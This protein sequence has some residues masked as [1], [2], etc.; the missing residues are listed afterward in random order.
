MQDPDASGTDEASNERRHFG[1]LTVTKVAFLFS[2]S[3]PPPLTRI[4]AERRAAGRVLLAQAGVTLGVAAACAVGWGAAAARSAAL[5]GGIGMAAAALMALALFRQAGPVSALRAAWGFYLGQALK[6]ALTIA[7]L[8][9][10][11]RSPGTVP[12]ALLAGYVASFAGYWA[13]PGAPRKG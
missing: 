6:V 7:L 5:G 8:V 3:V 12:A 10:A 1:G 4:Q 9:S 2:E 13:A 11:F